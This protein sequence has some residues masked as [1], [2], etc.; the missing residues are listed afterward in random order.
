MACDAC[1]YRAPLPGFEHEVGG[2]QALRKANAHVEIPSSP[3]VKPHAHTPPRK[4]VLVCV[5]RDCVKRGSLAA[6][7][8]IR[9]RVRA[10]GLGR[11][12][13]T[14]R[15]MCMG[16]CGEGPAVCVYPDG[17]WYRGVTAEDADEIFEQHLQ[18]NRPVGR[19]IDQVLSGT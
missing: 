7:D 10:E 15:V 14:T 9:R 5:S 12:I 2:L 17:V 13:Q 1:K 8:Q 11:Q 19:L 16:R 18:N 3:D 4:H 6:L